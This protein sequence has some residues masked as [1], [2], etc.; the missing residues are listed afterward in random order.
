GGYYRGRGIRRC[1]RGTVPRCRGHHAY[2]RPARRGPGPELVHRIQTM[3]RSADFQITDRIVT[4]YAGDER[5]ARVIERH[6]DYIRQETLSTELREGEPDAGAY[7][8]EAKLDGVVV[9][10]GVKRA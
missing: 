4:W 5:T 6:G 10:L 7:T 2:R 1:P 8:E 9:K 3:R